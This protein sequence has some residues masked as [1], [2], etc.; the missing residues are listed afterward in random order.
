MEGD[1]QAA[2]RSRAVAE[3]VAPDPAADLTERIA[4]LSRHVP[5]KETHL[6]S[7]AQSALVWDYG[8]NDWKTVVRQEG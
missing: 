5:E 6:E 7:R 4:Q 3:A 8:I 1:P 2:G